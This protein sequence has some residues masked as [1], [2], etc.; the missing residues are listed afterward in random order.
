MDQHK[1]MIKFDYFLALKTLLAQ[2]QHIF[3]GGT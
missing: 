1:I 3:L 2:I